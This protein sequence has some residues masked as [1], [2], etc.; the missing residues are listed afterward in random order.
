GAEPIGTVPTEVASSDASSSAHAALA[1]VAA[2]LV[3]RGGD[4]AA[5]SVGL[6]GEADLALVQVDPQVFELDG[7]EDGER[8]APN[9]GVD[10]GDG[11]DQE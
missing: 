9:A 1:A 10:H 7:D 3:P 11:I 8:D 5:E 6:A 2:S 4:V